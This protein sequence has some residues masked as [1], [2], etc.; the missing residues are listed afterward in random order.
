MNH[1]VYSDDFI[2]KYNS[3][4]GNNIVNVYT[5]GNGFVYVDPGP[6]KYT[7][8]LTLELLCDNFGIPNEL[9]YD[10]ATEKAVP[11]THFQSLVQKF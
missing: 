4:A 9:V 5:V 6:R 1:T 7:A 3:V 10:G 2:D 8:G 11:K